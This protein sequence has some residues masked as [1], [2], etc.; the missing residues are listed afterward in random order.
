MLVSLKEMD[1][2]VRQKEKERTQLDDVADNAHDEE[3]D[4][5]GLR[6]LEEFAT[7]GCKEN[8]CQWYFRA[9]M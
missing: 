3:T 2:Q 5:N 6:D 9:C 7:V 8:K 4:T 1:I